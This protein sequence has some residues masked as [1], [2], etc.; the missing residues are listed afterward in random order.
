M[1]DLIAGFFAPWIVYALIL[2][3]HLA[4]PARRVVGY[5]RDEATGKLLEYRLNGPLVLALMVLLWVTLGATEVLGW[6][7]LYRHRWSGLAGSCV[8]GVLFSLAMVLPVRSS[9]RSFLADLYLGRVEN[10]QFLNAKM[11]AKMFL[12]LVGAV[13]LGL[14]LLSFT[15][16][17]VL[18]FGADHSSG[19]LLYCTLFFW[20]VVDY[21]AFERV[22]L[23]TYDIF[24]ERVGFKLGFGCLTFYPYFYLVGLWLAAGLPDPGTPGW[25][26][27]VSAAVFFIGWSLSRGANMQKYIFKLDPERL[28]LGVVRP[29]VLSDGRNALLY[30]GFWGVA[31]HVNY[32]GE[33]LM[34]VGLTLVLGYPG[35]W[36]VWLYPLY[37]LALLVPRERADERRCAAKYGALWGEYVRL[38][39]RRILPWLY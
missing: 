39:P 20:F 24:A 30:S 29:R 5:V 34:A 35:R 4:L 32:L 17:H 14:N 2:G 6:D 25:L 15:A 12:Y 36:T 13:M 38:V 33:I 27:V 7:W 23:Y 3:L 22:H 19:V 8:L 18:A 31:R 37:Y 1:A 11:D 16:H 9:G 21:L 10:R 28:F 26:L